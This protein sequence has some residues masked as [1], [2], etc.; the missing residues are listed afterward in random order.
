MKPR[1]LFAA[2]ALAYASHTSTTF[3][4]AFLSDR[5]LVEGEGIKTGSFELHPGLAAEG[6]NDSNYFQGAGVER[7]VTP[8][9]PP[10]PGARPVDVNEPVIDTWRLRITPSLS[11]QSRGYRALREGGGQ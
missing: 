2:L 11:L 6:G 3:A 10:G 5:R 4:Q 1:F 8:L 9:T 7:G